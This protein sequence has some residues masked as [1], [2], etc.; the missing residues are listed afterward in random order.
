MGG[1][2]KQRWNK[3]NEKQR[4]MYRNKMVGREIVDGVAHKTNYADEKFLS[5]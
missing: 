1:G 3:D 5:L 2:G 4:T